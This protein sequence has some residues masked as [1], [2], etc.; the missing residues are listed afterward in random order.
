M[1]TFPLQ[2]VCMMWGL[3]DEDGRPTDPNLTDPFRWLTRQIKTGRVN[4][5]KMGRSWRMNLDQ[6]REAEAKFGAKIPAP[7]V[8]AEIPAPRTGLSVAS[9]KRRIA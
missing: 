5:M 7:A 1:R 9:Q 6:I 8:E 3:L 4:A 2:Q